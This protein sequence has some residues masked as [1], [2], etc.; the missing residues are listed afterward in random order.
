MPG[1]DPDAPVPFSADTSPQLRRMAQPQTQSF[2]AE[3]AGPGSNQP[4]RVAP[5]GSAQADVPQAAPRMFAPQNTHSLQAQPM[6]GQAMQAQPMQMQP[7]PTESP[8][9]APRMMA[10]PAPEAASQPLAM[11]N[12]PPAEQSSVAQPSS[13]EE[14]PFDV[15]EVFYG[16][17]RAAMVWPTGVLPQKYH[18]L[19]PAITC[20]MLGLAVGLLLTKIQQY[21]AAGLTVLLALT[22]AMVVGQEGWVQ[23]Q[24]VDRFLSNESV[25]YGKGQG[26][27]QVG[28]CRVSIP[29]THKAGVLESPSVFKLEFEEK[30]EDHLM[31]LEVK[32]REEEAFFHMLRERVAESPHAD[33]L[34]FIHGYNVTFEDA[35]RRTAQIAHDLK[36]QGA[37]VFFSWPSQGELFGYV[38][39]RGN[40]FW[41]A[42]HLKEFLMKVHQYSGAKSVH[43]IAH[44]MGNR[45]F[46][47]AIDSLADEMGPNSGKIFNE[48][49]LAAPD[50][51][52]KVFQD[53][54]APKICHLSQH[55][56]LYASQNDLALKASRAVNGYPRAGDT[57]PGILVLN[58]IDTIDVSQIDT[59]LLGHAYYGDNT[60]VIS[61]IY[62]LLREA[63]RPSQRNWLRDM[64]SPVGMYWYFDPGYNAI[65]RTPGSPAAR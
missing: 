65:S 25:V 50:V 17:D 49:I 11:S 39:D 2:S 61:D 5:E 29:K 59:S 40:S 21:L 34:L 58:G 54:I 10:A 36:F 57:G 51:D 37:P 14:E 3:S 33:L 52:A 63:R 64:S 62:A 12:E 43:L 28:T 19:L 35:A 47:A 41:A 7:G 44:S 38:T 9:F 27:L 48:V 23:Y 45:A 15:V 53:E 4:L 22:G 31:L 6:Q 55:V 1:Q 56:T 16:T 8:Q 26:D 32:S 46:G 18:A 13:V 42:S 24:K 60:S 20:V 30:Q